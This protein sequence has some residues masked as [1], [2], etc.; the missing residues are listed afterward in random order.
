MQLSEM[1]LFKMRFP[2]KNN[3]FNKINHIIFHKIKYIYNVY[4]YKYYKFIYI[5]QCDIKQICVVT[6]LYI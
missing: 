5:N 3:I 1:K 4:I 2:I 6:Y